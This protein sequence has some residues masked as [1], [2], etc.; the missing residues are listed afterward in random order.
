MPHDAKKQVNKTKQDINKFISTVSDKNYAAAHK[1]L[2][3]AV[4][5]KVLDRIDKATEKPLF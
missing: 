2:Q 1:Y 4:E 3:G 5:D